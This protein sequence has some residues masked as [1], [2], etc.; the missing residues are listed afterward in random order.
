LLAAAASAAVWI[1]G[2]A[3]PLLLW[4][5]YLYLCFWGIENNGKPKIPEAPPPPVPAIHGT[6]NI[7]GPG[8]DLHAAIKCGPGERDGCTQQPLAEHAKPGEYAHAPQWLV[9]A[10]DLA[11]GFYHARVEP[12]I[13]PAGGYIDRLM[14]NPC[15][16]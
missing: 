10:A 13:R 14:R 15:V 6:I 3:L 16:A 4:V 2:A 7:Q 1:G 9:S 12:R 11:A 5:G 8:V